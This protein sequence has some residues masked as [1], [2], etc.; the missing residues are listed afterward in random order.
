LPERRLQVSEVTYVS[1]VPRSKRAKLRSALETEDT[2]EVTWT[3]KRLLFGS[4]FYFSGP[5]KLVRKTHAY[6]TLWLA[7]D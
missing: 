7:T 3:E 4:E 5:A 2:G 6:I 1:F